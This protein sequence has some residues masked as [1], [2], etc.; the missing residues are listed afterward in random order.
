MKRCAIKYPLVLSNQ[1]VNYREKKW[2]TIG[3]TTMKIYKWVPISEQK[4]K[5]IMKGENKENRSKPIP[6]ET[7]TISNSSHFGLA[8]EDS[9]TCKLNKFY[10]FDVKYW[11]FEYLLN[12]P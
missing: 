8:T 6:L 1:N 12:W 2:V 11:N 10:N 7:S 5:L 3:E 9:N 4:K